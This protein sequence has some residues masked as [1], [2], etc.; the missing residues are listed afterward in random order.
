[1]PCRKLEK[2][3]KV[4]M[5]KITDKYNTLLSA[6][7]VLWYNSSNVFYKVKIVFDFGY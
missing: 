4:D 6:L 3:R 5:K 1:M 7:L 2:H